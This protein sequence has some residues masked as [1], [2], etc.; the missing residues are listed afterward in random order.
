MSARN[1]P[2]KL[3]NTPI[4]HCIQQDGVKEQRAVAMA[5]TGTPERVFLRTVHRLAD[6]ARGFVAVDGR[7]NTLNL[8]S[9]LPP[10][11]IAECV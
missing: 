10:P 2:A 4:R 6:H 5:Q 8:C 3:N 7:Y 11:V 9:L 1:G